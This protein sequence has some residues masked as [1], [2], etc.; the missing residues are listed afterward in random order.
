MFCPLAGDGLPELLS[1]SGVARGAPD[2][3]LED[4]FGTESHALGSSCCPSPLQLEQINLSESRGNAES[5]VCVD[6]GFISGF[7]PSILSL[8][9]T[10]S[11][12]AWQ[13]NV[14]IF[15]KLK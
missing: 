9:I 5:E 1:V 11:I 14:S 12:A 13:E 7:L 15:I 6:T 4:S 2:L 10:L 3:L 8:D